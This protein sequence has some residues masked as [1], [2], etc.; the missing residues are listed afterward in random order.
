MKTFLFVR[1]LKSPRAPL[2][3]LYILYVTLWEPALRLWM[4]YTCNRTVV[5]FEICFITVY[6]KYV[7]E[8]LLS[9]AFDNQCGN[10]GLW[11]LYSYCNIKGFKVLK[12]LIF[13]DTVMKQNIFLNDINLLCSSVIF[14]RYLLIC[15]NWKKFFI[16]KV[17]YKTVLMA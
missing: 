16:H 17:P 5:D 3:F 14:L 10:F 4:V 7:C 2:F 13:I 1:N 15:M 8:N 6:C 11:M 9:I 12:S